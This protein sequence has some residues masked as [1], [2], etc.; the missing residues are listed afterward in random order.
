MQFLK[1]HITELCFM[2]LLCGTLWGAVQLI[3]SGHI[4]NGDFALYIRQ[5]QS[6]QY[7]DMQQVFSDMQEMI[8][9][10]TYQRYSPILYPWG[11]PL[12]LFPCVA[13]FGINYFAFKIVGVICLVGAFIFLYYHPILSKERFRMSVL[14]VLALLTGNIFYWGYVNSV[15]SEL[16][17][18]CFLMFSFWTMN[19]LYVLKEQTEKRTILYIGLGILLFFT[20]Q[21]RTEGY[22]LFISLIVLQWKN[23]LLG[24]RF[25]LPYASALCIWFVFTLVFPSG[26]TEH[27]EHFKVVTL[28]NLL[29]NI[30]TFYEYPAQI[31]YIPFSL[32]NLFFW[33]NCL[34]GLYISSRKLTA[35]S[36]YLVSTIMLLICW[37]YDVIRYWLSLFPLCFIF[38][39][40]GFRFMCMVWGKKAGKWVLYPIIGILICSVWKV[41]IKYATSPIQIYTT[42]NPNVEGES[43]QEMY[44]FLRTNT[45]QEDWIPLPKYCRKDDS[46]INR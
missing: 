28:T 21:I 10:S 26:Y 7:G 46:Y 22:F 45:A 17:F 31:L 43:A 44:A 35:E 16:P 27:F 1:K 41:S 32:F 36:V 29:H 2:L 8:A 24:W 6:I 23:R 18:F 30:Q 4:F 12:L 5:A 42:I 38:F 3:V 9:H 20:A 40:Q 13:L 33:V 25:F 37:P 15:S 39:I 14:L 34:L 11:Y 19:K